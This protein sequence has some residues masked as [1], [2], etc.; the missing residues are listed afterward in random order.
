MMNN[1]KEKCNWTFD[2]E[3]YMYDT[4]CKNAFYFPEGVRLEVEPSFKYCPFCSG[5]IK[6]VDDE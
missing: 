2:N 3:Q 5:E 6:E 1:L 4:E